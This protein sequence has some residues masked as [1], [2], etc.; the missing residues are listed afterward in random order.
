MKKKKLIEA[1]QSFED[2]DNICIGDYHNY[3]PEIRKICGKQDIIMGYC[4]CLDPGHEGDCWD[5]CKG[6][7]FEENLETWNDLRNSF[8][9]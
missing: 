9:K 3:I 7:D 2:D 8:T 1:L 4:C 6:V 5:S